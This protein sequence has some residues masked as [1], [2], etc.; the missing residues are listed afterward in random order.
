MTNKDFNTLT[1]E[2]PI[3]PTVRNV[4]GSNKFNPIPLQLAQKATNTL[5]LPWPSR[6]RLWPQGGP[7][8]TSTLRWRSWMSGCMW[9]KD[10]RMMMVVLKRVP[11][12]NLKT[13]PTGIQHPQFSIMYIVVV[14]SINTW[15]LPQWKSIHIEK[16]AAFSHIMKHIFLPLF[17][18]IHR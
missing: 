7:V 2:N 6:R 11:F 17:W 15:P 12:W 9:L 4:F 3:V 5:L 16:Y 13:G 14:R 8:S 10:Y 18:A 1:V